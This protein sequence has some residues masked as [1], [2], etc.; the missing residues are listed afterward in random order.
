MYPP[1][2]VRRQTC[3]H[4][5]HAFAF[6]RQQQSRAIHLQRRCP[7]G[8]PRGLAVAV[9][10]ARAERIPEAI[11]TPANPAARNTDRREITVCLNIRVLLLLPFRIMLH[12]PRHRHV[13]SY[14]V[15]SKLVDPAAESTIDSLMQAHAR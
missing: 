12:D 3:R 10:T 6:S 7:I 15:K 11:P 4:R 1:H 8:V 9:G 14:W 5:L 13:Y 2:V